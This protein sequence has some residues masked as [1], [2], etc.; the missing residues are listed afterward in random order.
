MFSQCLVLFINK[1]VISYLLVPGQKPHIALQI[2]N[3][4]KSISGYLKII[5]KFLNSK[6]FPL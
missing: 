3:F 2:E 1:K 6:L 4:H 5:R